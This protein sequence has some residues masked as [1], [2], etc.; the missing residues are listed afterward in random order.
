VKV[1]AGKRSLRE[2]VSRLSRMSAREIWVRS[3]QEWRKRADEA[4]YRL[5]FASATE[6]LDESAPRGAFFF[7]PEAACALARLLSERLPD[8]ASRIIFQARKICVHK[9]DLLGYEDLDYG[10]EIDWSLDAVH[11][12]RAPRL[13]WFRIPF[14]D[15]EA[16][17]DHKVT[18]ELNRHQHLVTLAKANL[19]TGEERYQEEIVAQWL[20]WYKSNPYPL[21]INWA[22]A[23]EVAFRSFS[24]LWVLHLLETRLPEGFAW[25]V[26]RALG[27]SA[28]FLDRYLS[29][30]FAPNTHL[31]GEGVALFFIGTLLP[32]F[33]S[34][35]RWRELGWRT[36]CEQLR[37]QVL[38]DG[39]HYEQSIYY[40]VYAL[41]FFLH[42]RVLAARS[43]MPIEPEMDQT[44][45][46]MCES[47]A[48]LSQ[49]GAP[50]RFGDDDGGRLFDGRRNRTEHMLDPLAIASVMFGRGDLRTAAGLTE[51]CLWLFGEE[52]VRQFDQLPAVT[53][54]AMSFR[55][56]A[57]GFCSMLGGSRQITIDGGPHGSGRG[58]HGHSDALSLQWIAE[59]R[60][61][62]TDPG[63]FCY[64]GE[65]RSRFR[66]AAAHNTM[67]V[68]GLDQADSAGPF[69]WRRLPRV[70]V[71]RWTAGR[72]LDL[73][74]GSHDGYERLLQPVAH[75]RWVIGWKSGAC[76]VRDEALGTGVHSLEIAW[77]LGPEFVEHGPALAILG[78]G[79][80][81]WSRETGDADWSPVYGVK[82]KA[83]LL[84]FRAETALPAEHVTLLVPVAGGLE[85]LESPAGLSAYR[86]LADDRLRVLLFATAPGCWN[87]GGWSSDAAFVA[88]EADP[89]SSRVNS[90]VLAGGS[91]FSASGR[92][93]LS[94]EAPLD[95]LE[96]QR[97]D[98][99]AAERLNAIDLP[100]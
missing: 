52:G 69:S 80:G 93:L 21:G 17:G 20:H 54:S 33:R 84:M 92:V 74:V 53:K 81:D 12:I 99:G 7:A 28:R 43:G 100:A 72:T 71:E 39:M 48:A 57:S 65:E 27:V 60:D 56:E 47:L 75:R 83:P 2:T 31:L 14:L 97:E 62:L 94:R 16:V 98:D 24:W 51:E 89:Q 3:A 1:P 45:A 68:D 96:W 18:W 91:V 25:E 30:Y 86:C 46:R 58:G 11:G 87:W 90:L 61:W 64:V 37:K 85:R 78:A 8:E 38:P 9:F 55:L 35:R 23:L 50:P 19:L 26:R 44:I 10:Q 79:T 6:P 22:S 59:G 29:T 36:V 70:R 66:G 95:W 32:G 15:F 88:I 63:A 76:L 41:D 4:R 40:H 67:R 49:A 73:F 5:G 77:H 82:V 13:V 42:A 34:A